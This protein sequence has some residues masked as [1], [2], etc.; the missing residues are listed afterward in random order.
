MSLGCVLCFQVLYLWFSDSPERFFSFANLIAYTCLG[1]LDYRELVQHIKRAGRRGPPKDEDHKQRIQTTQ[2]HGK[3][4]GHGTEK[5]TGTGDVAGINTKKLEMPPMRQLHPGRNKP[6]LYQRMLRTDAVALQGGPNG[7]HSQNKLDPT[8]D[9]LGYGLRIPPAPDSAV[10]CKRSDVLV[11]CGLALLE[12]GGFAEAKG[13]RCIVR[14]ALCFEF[15]ALMW[16][17][18]LWLTLFSFFL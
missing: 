11:R 5:G 18:T 10:Y 13:M 15:C 8:V 12:T 17:E 3:G 9:V 7:K 2:R 16:I 4:T 14:C 6:T 1:E